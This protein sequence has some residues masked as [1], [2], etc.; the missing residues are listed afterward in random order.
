MK[1]NMFFVPDWI[2]VLNHYIKID[3]R[4]IQISLYLYI[5]LFPYIQVSFLYIQVSFLLILIFSTNT[6]C[7]NMARSHP[8][9]VVGFPEL[10]HAFASFATLQNSALLFGTCR[11]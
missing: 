6:K 7:E 10:L 5:R 11:F 4:Y 1:G 2:F 9:L 3:Y 8:S